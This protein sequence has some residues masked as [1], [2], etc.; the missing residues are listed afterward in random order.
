MVNQNKL[1]KEG[2]V[3][4]KATT[5]KKSNQA[6]TSATTTSSVV[7]TSNNKKNKKKNKKDNNDYKEDNASDS[8][9]NPS[10][11]DNHSTNDPVEVYK[12]IHGDEIGDNPNYELEEDLRNKKAFQMAN[13]SQEEIDGLVD[14]S[15]SPEP[16]VQ[17]VSKV[18]SASK[19][20]VSRDFLQE[21]IHI[22]QTKSLGWLYNNEL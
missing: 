1:I 16:V 5:S 19:L 3:A 12:D 8:H 10:S 20:K 7:G 9:S 2:T 18:R 14:Y 13:R 4:K 21:S 15:E 17:R 6:D 11:I 22:M